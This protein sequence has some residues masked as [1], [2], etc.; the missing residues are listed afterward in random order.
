[1][2]LLLPVL[3][4]GAPQKP[5][6]CEDQA[7]EQRSMPHHRQANSRGKG[8]SASTRPHNPDT[9]TSSSLHKRH[10]AFP[11]VCKP[12]W[13]RPPPGQSWRPIR[14]RS[15]LWAHSS[16]SSD[17]V[18]KRREGAHTPHEQEPNQHYEQQAAAHCMHAQAKPRVVCP[19]HRPCI[20]PLSDTPTSHQAFPPSSPQCSLKV[21]TTCTYRFP[22]MY[23]QP[24][25]GRQSSA[26]G[27]AQVLRGKAE[28]W[29]TAYIT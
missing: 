14:Q 19:P 10:R 25:A 6:A 20:T 21:Q 28:S 29:R 11:A 26:D 24:K 13:V 5:P 23:S 16:V 7:E 27:C 22:T 15:T 12:N 1:M 3:Q 8:L 4:L 17:A 18:N 9:E 2:E